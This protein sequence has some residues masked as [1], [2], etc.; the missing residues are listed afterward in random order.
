MLSIPAILGYNLLAS[1]QPLG[2]GT[3]IMDLEEYIVGN[4]M[5]PL[6][7]LVYVIFCVSRYG[8]GWDNFIKEAN[9]GKGLKVA[10]WMKPIFQIVL[11]A[12]IAFIYIYGMINFQ[13]K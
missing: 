10:P 13:W 8:W 6:G 4:F 9:A 1:V 5:L 12:L 3:T 2:A 11:P 7:S